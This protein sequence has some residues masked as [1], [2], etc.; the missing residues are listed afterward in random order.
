MLPPYCCSSAALEAS[1]SLTHTCLPCHLCSHISVPQHTPSSPVISVM[2][3]PS[4]MLL[5]ASNL[6]WFQ[7]AVIALRDGRVCMFSPLLC[8]LEY[9]VGFTCECVYTCAW[10]EKMTKG[11]GGKRIPNGW[12]ARRRQ[13]YSSRPHFTLMFLLDAICPFCIRDPSK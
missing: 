7:S 13:W 2:E 5:Q 8:P 11:A 4:L 6:I 10:R 12:L 1:C 9:S 3:V